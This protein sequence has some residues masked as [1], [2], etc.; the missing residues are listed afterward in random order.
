[1]KKASPAASSISL[2]GSSEIK[3]FSGDSVR[4]TISMEEAIELMKLAFEGF[5]ALNSHIPLRSLVDS[6]DGSITLFFK[7]AFDKRLDNFTIK[8][9][10]QNDD[11]PSVGLPAIAGVVLLLDSKSGQI[12]SIMDG[13]SITAL[14][15]GAISGLATQYLSRKESKTMALFGCG[16]QG[17]TQLEAVLSV[18]SI[19]KVYLFDTNRSAALKLMDDMVIGKSLYM[20]FTNDLDVLC[21]ADIISTA[22]GSRKPLFK[23]DHL[24]PGVHINAIGSYKPDMNEIASEIIRVSTLFVDQREGCL[25]ET[26]DILIPLNKGLIERDHIVGELAEVISHKVKGRIN[27]QDLTVFKSVGI[28]IQDLFVANAV[29]EKQI[30]NSSK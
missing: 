13:E 9:L 1:M 18:R 7:P 5:N 27:D 25:S 6:P 19:E 10:A 22:T 2:N 16:T 4:S 12:L 29:Y 15:T 24:K 30:K 21:E 23:L 17:R 11:N 20:E 8:L 3:I 26:G 14:R 28:A